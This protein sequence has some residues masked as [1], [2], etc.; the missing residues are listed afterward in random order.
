MIRNSLI[1]CKE[2]DKKKIKRFISLVENLDRDNSLNIS[3]HA[4]ANAYRAKLTINP[5]KK[6]QYLDLFSKEISSA[7]ANVSKED[8]FEVIFLRYLIENNIPKGL[9]FS[10]NIIED[11]KELNE[12]INTIDTKSFNPEYMKFITNVLEKLR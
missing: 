12:S 10:N 9:G 5:L 11:K 8:R 2:G 7:V 4:V 1:D 3:F 6:I